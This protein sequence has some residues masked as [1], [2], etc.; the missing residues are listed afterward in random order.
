MVT[1]ERIPLREARLELTRY[2][3]VEELA[4]VGSIS[5]PV[6][7]VEHGDLELDAILTAHRA[8]GAAVLEGLVMNSMR[9]GE[10]AGIHLLGPGD[11]LVPRSD[12]LPDWLAGFES[13]SAGSVRLGLFG[14]ELLAAAY[15]WPRVL[16]GL[17]ACVG[18]QMQRLTAQLVICQLPRVD[19]RVLAML[20]LLSESWGH[21][22]PS[23]IRLPL[24]L[25][26]E[27]LG[28][29]VGAARPTVTLALG[30][31]ADDGAIV[32]QDSGWLLLTPPPHPAAPPAK[33]LPPEVADDAPG[34]WTIEAEPVDRSEAYAELRDTVHRLRAQHQLDRQAT[35]DQLE[36]VRTGRIR[37]IAARRRITEATL[38]RP[39][40]PS[41]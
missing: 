37:M 6:V 40:P 15:R 26:H 30:K 20:W 3:T 9:I 4:E 8:F 5:L 18:D 31:L 35:R 13:R 10:Q 27:T 1:Q 23:G 21:V 28:A 16:Q 32:H 38:K 24:T 29:L 22:T 11:L 39:A 25:T 33:I 2:L 36:Q 12:L 19:D 14:N 34:L 41:S 7:T 17:Y